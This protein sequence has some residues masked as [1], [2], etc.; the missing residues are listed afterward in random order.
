M[1]SLIPNGVNGRV[2][3]Y[4]PQTRGV[5][6]RVDP[7]TFSVTPNAFGE[8]NA[9]NGVT[10]TLYAFN[11]NTLQII[12]GA[13]EVVR[14]NIPLSY[15]PGSM[16]INAVSNYLYIA[17][18][19]GQSIEVRNGST[20]ALVS[21]FALSAFGVTPNGSMAVDSTRSRI[22]VVQNPSN[23]SGP[24]LLVIEDVINAVT[25]SHCVTSGRVH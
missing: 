11:G 7:T 1:G 21:T 25:K 24:V 14:Y 12:S 20:G 23:N 13:T 3:L 16:G 5:S 8:V 15:N 2:Y 19:I 4:E 9:I 10:N 6:E 18:P 22:Y 17:N